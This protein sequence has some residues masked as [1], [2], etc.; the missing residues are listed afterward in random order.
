M[1]VL[2]SI[3]ERH[4]TEGATTVITRM[5]PDYTPSVTRVLGLRY[6]THVYTKTR[7]GTKNPNWR[8]AI[9]ALQ[10]AGTP[11]SLVT[12][13]CKNGFVHYRAELKAGYPYVGITTL[14]EE[15]AREHFWVQSEVAE[16]S[17]KA[18]ETAL[19]NFLKNA[20]EA[21]APFKGMTFLGELK[22]TLKMIRNPAASLRDGISAYIKRARRQTR[23]YKG[24][25]VRKV[26]T[27]LW[28]ESVYGWRPLIS[29]IASGVEAYKALREK[30]DTERVVGRSFDSWTTTPSRTAIY[31]DG[32]NYGRV[33]LVRTVSKVDRVSFKGVCLTQFNEE[34]W[35]MGAAEGVLKTCGFDLTEFIPTVWELIPNSFVF[36]MFTNVGD[37]LAAIHGMQAKF[38]WYSCGRK[39]TCTGV[40]S[41]QPDDAGL[42]KLVVYPNGSP[43][44]SFNSFYSTDSSCEKV[45]VSRSIPELRLPALQL[46]LPGK[47][48]Q[49][50][51]LLA[52]ASQKLK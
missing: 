46:E 51:N 14:L 23:R 37:I 48:F 1:E 16:L 22:E 11:Y 47:P 44:A 5:L 4:Y 12:T 21:T 25:K 15:Y 35:Q 26:L 39:T 42:A 24:P 40:Q 7:M 49:W 29:D 36:D 20:S 33:I 13:N 30:R 28:L 2:E 50:A 52:L 18:Y 32:G 27:D 43:R 8:K 41:Y 31:L 17:S 45:I 6:L 10:E 9:K 34:D 3:Q 19:G 38:V